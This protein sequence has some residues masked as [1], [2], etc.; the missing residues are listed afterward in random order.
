GHDVKPGCLLQ[1]DGFI[2]GA[3]LYALELR[4]SEAPGLPVVPRFAQGERP[5]KTADDIGM[6]RNHRRPQR[7]GRTKR[8]ARCEWM[9]VSPV[10]DA[11]VVAE[12]T[13]A[14]GLRTIRIGKRNGARNALA[15]N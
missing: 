10:R 5:K 9:D 11:S 6:G 12:T 2:V 7:S 8:P 4:V 3:I 13:T 14:C 15:A 1:G